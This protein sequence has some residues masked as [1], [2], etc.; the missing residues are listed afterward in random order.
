MSSYTTVF[1]LFASNGILL[2]VRSFEVIALI[3]LTALLGIVREGLVKLHGLFL[4]LTV[5][6]MSLALTL[7]WYGA[8]ER[9]DIIDQYF[10]G[11]TYFY[12]AFLVM[13]IAAIGAILQWLFV[14]IIKTNSIRVFLSD[15]G[16]S[17]KVILSF[18]S[19]L[20]LLEDVKRKGKQVLEARIARGLSGKTRMEK[21]RA[22]LSTISP[23]VYTSIIAA[24]NRAE[25]WSHRGIDIY[26]QSKSA[27]SNKKMN[28]SDYCLLIWFTGIPFLYFWV[29]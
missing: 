19:T 3:W 22:I 16:F 23:V 17:G 6:P 24:I 8:S 14:P 21:W 25:F 13:R 26:E 12:I 7:V 10:Y 15:L 27:E 20:V 5:I 9:P 29:Q 28:I 4:L 2:S 1:I 18:V 11:K